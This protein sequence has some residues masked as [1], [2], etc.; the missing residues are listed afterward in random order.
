MYNYLC[1][2]YL[3]VLHFNHFQSY[4]PPSSSPSV[5]GAHNVFLSSLMRLD[6][7]FLTLPSA[8]SALCTALIATPSTMMPYQVNTYHCVTAE[9]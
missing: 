7:L 6:S 4:S 8:L 9:V 2:A 3:K 1:P 5:L